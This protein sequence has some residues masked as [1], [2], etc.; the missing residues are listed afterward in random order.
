MPFVTFIVAAT[1]LALFVNLRGY[2]NGFV[3]LAYSFSNYKF[4]NTCNIKI[5]LLPVHCF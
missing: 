2:K 1:S 3:A 4:L 5:K